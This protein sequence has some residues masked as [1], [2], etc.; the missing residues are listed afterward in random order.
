[1]EAV[2]AFIE[3]DLRR[4]GQ[5]GETWLIATDRRI[6][7]F[8]PLDSRDSRLSP[9]IP[10]NEIQKLVRRDV[11]GAA[12]IEAVT[13]TEA[14]LVARMTAASV[15]D[16]TS[17]LPEMQQL[18]PEVDQSATRHSRGSR[19]KEKKV[20]PNCGKPIA[21]WSGICVDCLDKRKLFF[22][23]MGRVRGYWPLITLGLVTMVLVQGTD[24]VQ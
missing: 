7:L 12:L 9:D 17:V 24:L 18:L 22:R 8:D 3:C 16:V 21:P 19:E 23:L 20:C 6:A 14:I 2:R 10:T 1:G 5:F 11:H 15:D 4:S 13:E